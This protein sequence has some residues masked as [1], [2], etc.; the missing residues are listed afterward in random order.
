MWRDVI[1]VIDNIIIRLF[2]SERCQSVWPAW[3]S[4]G[5][6]WR[7]TKHRNTQPRPLST[8]TCLQYLKISSQSAL[9]LSQC[10]HSEICLHTSRSHSLSV[11]EVSPALSFWY[12]SRSAPAKFLILQTLSRQEI[13][14]Y[15]G[16]GGNI[17]F[18]QKTKLRKGGQSYE[19]KSRHPAPI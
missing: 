19:E 4:G 10:L 17:Y 7:G 14:V 18:H 3:W 6:A 16:L 5:L 1:L 11:L 13:I 8:L 12:F 9:V 2:L 15:E